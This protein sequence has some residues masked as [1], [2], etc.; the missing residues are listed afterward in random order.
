MQPPFGKPVT[1]REIEEYTSRGDEVAFVRLANAMLASALADVLPSAVVPACSERVNVPDAGVDAEVALTLD[2]SPP[3]MQGLLGPGRTIYQFKWRDPAARSRAQIL[4][5]LGGK[6]SKELA[7]LRVRADKLPDRYVLL[8]NLHL[9]ASQ[10]RQLRQAILTGSPEFSGRPIVIWGAAEIAAHLNTHPL[11]RHAFFSAGTFCTLG[12]AHQE[13][14]NQYRGFPWPDIIGR[15]MEI[16]A[17]RE[18][19]DRG[20]DRLL[21]V[22][23]LPCVGKTRTVLEALTP[24]GGRVVWASHPEAVSEDYLRDLDDE[25][26][27]ILVLD[28]CE[29]DV[30]ERSLRWATSRSYLQTILVGRQAREWA[31]VSSLALGPLGDLEAGRLLH[32]IA[33]K[34]P[35]LQETWLIRL[36]GG[37]PGLAIYAA[38]EAIDEKGLRGLSMAATDFRRT[39]GH[40]LSQRVLAPTTPEER[41]ALHVV[42]L[43]THI[44]VKE[45]AY[46]ELDAVC[47]SLGY[48]VPEVRSVLPALVE[49][50]VV[51]ER[52]RFVEVVPPLLAEDLAAEALIGR[53][54][55]LA[56]LL[57][58]LDVGA[59]LRFLARL[60]NIGDSGE[61]DRALESIYTP[62]GWFPDLEALLARPREFRS[63]TPGHPRGAAACLYRLLGPLPASVLR[64]RVGGTARREIVW[65]LQDLS[66]RPDTFQ[67]AAEVLFCLAEAENERFGNNATGIFHTLFHPFHPEVSAPLPERLQFLREAAKSESAEKRRLVAAAAGQVGSTEWLFVLHHPEGPHI[68]DAP[69]WPKT[70]AELRTYFRDLLDILDELSRDIDEGVRIEARSRLIAHCGEFLRL[71]ISEEDGAGIVNKTFTLLR[72]FATQATEAKVVADIRSQLEMLLEEIETTMGKAPRGNRV[73]VSLQVLRQQ[74]LSF[75]GDL[76]DDSFPSR[77]KRWAGPHSWK[78]ELAEFSVPEGGITPS[79]DGLQHL[80]DEAIQDPNRLNDSLLEWL[81]GPEA[82]HAAWFFIRLGEQDSA[83][84]WR[85]RLVEKVGLPR[86]PENFGWYMSGWARRD[87]RWAEEYVDRLLV[88]DPETAEGIFAA[89]LRMMASTSGVDRILRLLNSEK[90]QRNLLIQDLAWRWTDPLS[91]VDFVRLFQGLDDGSWSTSLALLDVLAYQQW[92]VGGL[93]SEFRSSVWLIL[94]RTGSVRTDHQARMWDSLAAYLAES[95]PNAVLDLIERLAGREPEP[96]ARPVFEF[97]RN[98]ASTWKAL[99]RFSRPAL[100]RRLLGIS[101]SSDGGRYWVHWCARHL[102]DPSQDGHTLLEFARNNAEAGALAV[103]YL[104]DAT[105]P[106]FWELVREIIAGFGDSKRVIARVG[107]SIHR[108]WGWGS[109]APVFEERRRQLAR[110]A[111][112]PDP[113][114]SKWARGMARALEADVEREELSDKEEFLWEYDVTRPELLRMLQDRQSPDRLWAIRRI[115]LHARPEEAIRLLT[116]DEI[117]EVLPDVDLPEWTRR[118][119]EAYVAHRSHGG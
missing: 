95:E 41:R 17:I 3:E 67:E 113:R 28:N 61:V 24:V 109:L 33:P 63:L 65:A 39:L 18:F 19:V 36:T 32:A 105:K 11:L 119:W 84:S 51:V 99:A 35:S 40:V 45:S 85:D 81:L 82:S 57:V 110:M 50:G 5:G 96:E 53:P 71:G 106:G 70:R 97:L 58:R 87:Q 52:G 4:R 20:V 111:E 37:L 54:L 23:G 117:R 9:T 48:E 8:T 55:A 101:A 94:E 15:E 112:D 83:Y 13:L 118:I 104:L 91:L 26:G 49:K 21:L 42:S 12:V 14:K 102:I 34:L 72:Q 47:R 68:P 78:D 90:L 6:V 93:P 88:T 116:V 86:W 2:A 10:T 62:D 76:T 60:R 69:R 7:S 114:V 92:R 79:R 46:D 25:T 74:A 56:G 75:L 77:L 44:G 73:D 30:L 103:I 115:L 89:T 29:G 16:K 43:L 80:A 1:A 27:T 108:A 100:V 64:D 59:R 107:A 66:L 98:H 38:C 22:T 31:G